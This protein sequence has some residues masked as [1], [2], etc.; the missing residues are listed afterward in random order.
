MKLVFSPTIPFPAFAILKFP[1]KSNE[2]KIIP[3][4][5]RFV[6]PDLSPVVVFN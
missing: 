1:A 6:N 5:R 4:K 2:K 3:L